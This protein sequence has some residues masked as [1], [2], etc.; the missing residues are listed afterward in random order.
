LGITEDAGAGG[1][2]RHE[3]VPVHPR[4]LRHWRQRRVAQHRGATQLT[5]LIC[6]WLVLMHDIHSSG[7]F[8]LL[9]WGSWFR[10]FA[11]G[12]ADAR[13]CAGLCRNAWISRALSLD[14]KR[15]ILIDMAQ[16]WL[17]M[18]EEQRRP[19]RQSQHRSSSN[20]NNRV[21][22]KDD[23]KNEI[24]RLSWRRHEP[25]PLSARRCKLHG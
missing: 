9:A 24:G 17:Q 15:E 4:R 20:S 11:M 10:L 5:V 22:S 13:W 25:L 1:Q 3:P 21:R 23:N 19:A 16:T 8:F 14:A 7:A 12:G 2:R 18:A 6:S